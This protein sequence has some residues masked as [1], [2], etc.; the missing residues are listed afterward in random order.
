LTVSVATGAR[1]I[2]VASATA[3]VPIGVIADGDLVAFMARWRTGARDGR[4]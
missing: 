2:L 4:R 3:Q 1:H